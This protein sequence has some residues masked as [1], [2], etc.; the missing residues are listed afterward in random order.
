MHYSN[1]KLHE[2]Q[3]VIIR[4]LS[5]RPEARFNDLLIEGLGSEHMNYHLQKLVELNLVEKV[6]NRYKLTDKGKDY[7]N[8]LDDNIEIIEKQPKSSVLLR[9]VQKRPGTDEA[10]HLVC[11]RLRQPYFGKVGRLTGKVRFGE[12]LEQ[13][14]LRELY[15]ETGLKAKNIMLESIYHKVRHRPDST[16]AQD[17]IFYVFFIRD[18]CGT[19]INKTPYQENFWLTQKELQTNKDLDVFDDFTLDNRLEPDKLKFSESVAIAEGF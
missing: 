18:V 1:V 8:L 4:N 12:T 3:L 6:K 2:F 16:T 17:V 7:S 19:F 14:A 11:R 15:E 5:L 10:E 9:V 13:A